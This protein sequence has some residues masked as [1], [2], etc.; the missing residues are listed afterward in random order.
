MDRRRVL[1][2]VAAIIAALGT[3]LVFLYVRGADDRANEKFHAV[4]V[5]KAVKQ[6]NAGETVAAAQAAGKIEESSVG[7]GERLP[8]ALD[9]LAPIEGQIAQTNIFVG[10]QIVA[11][12]F[13]SAPASTN[14]LSVPDGKIAVSINLTDTARVAGFVNPGDK[15]AIFMSSN[16]GAGLGSFTRLL[17]SNI[18]V[19]AVGTTTVVSTTK[20]DSTGAQTTEQLPRTLF[21]LGV[22]QQEAEKIMFATGSGELAFAKIGKD[23]KLVPDPGANADN[24]FK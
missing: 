11:S 20:T 3:L 4:K 12:K 7:E 5:L 24:L 8:E 18:E 21:T 13:G 1:L 10:E 17:L 15:V 16:G 9:S 2:V 22:T 6:I 19:I 14:A 23:A